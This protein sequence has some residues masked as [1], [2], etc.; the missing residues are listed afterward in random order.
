MKIKK[1]FTLP[2]ILITIVVIGIIAAITI[3][4]IFQVTFFLK[5]AVSSF[6]HFSALSDTFF[7]NAIKT[8]LSN[9]V[10]NSLQSN[11]I[12]KENCPSS[13]KMSSAKQDSG[14]SSS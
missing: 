8:P 12:G 3:N 14:S 7:I 13:S 1:G 11:S 9:Y 5:K 2:E 10:L 6:G 4:I